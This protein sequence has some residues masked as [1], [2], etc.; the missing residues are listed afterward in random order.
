MKYAVLPWGEPSIVILTPPIFR[1]LTYLPNV[2]T[3]FFSS[4]LS[5]SVMKGKAITSMSSPRR[6]RTLHDLQLIGMRRPF[7]GRRDAR[8]GVEHLPGARPL[9]FLFLRRLGQ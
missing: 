4:T 3:G 1:R 6:G 9:D 8:P 5:K 2:L 7:V